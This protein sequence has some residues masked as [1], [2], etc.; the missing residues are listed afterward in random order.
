MKRPII[1]LLITA[2]CLSGF[3]T[4]RPRYAG[5]NTDIWWQ[6]DPVPNHLQMFN[7]QRRIGLHSR[8]PLTSI[9]SPKVPVIL[10][11]FSDLKFT[12]GLP[13]DESCVTSDQQVMVNDF[14]DKFCNGLRDGGYY[15]DHGSFGAI[16]EYF[17]DQSDGLFTPDFVVI[18]PVTLENGYATYGKNEK[19]TDSNISEFYKESV[20]KAQDLFNDWNLFDNDHNGTVD[21]MF[22]IYAGKGENFSNNPNAIWPKERPSG[23]T[24][25]S[26]TIGCYACCNEILSTG[27]PDGIGTFI[28]ELSHALGLPDLYDFGLLAYGMD[29][30]DIMDCGCYCNNSYWP[31]GY[32][33]Y[34]KDFMGWKPLVTLDDTEATHI[35]LKPQHAGGV[36]YKMVNPDNPDEYYVI[37]NRQNEEWDTYIGCMDYDIKAH[38]MV[39]THI[40]YA[41]SF[42]TG[43]WVNSTI[44][45]QRCTLVPA[46]GHLES[47][48][49][50]GCSYD[51]Y[52]KSS[53]GNP[54]PGTKNVTSCEA[55]KPTI[56]RYRDQ[57]TSELTTCKLPAV[58]IGAMDQALRNIVEHEDGTIEFDY[59][60]HGKMPIDADGL[61]ESKSSNETKVSSYDI[62]GRKIDKSQKGINIIRMSDGTTR[63]VLIK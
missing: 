18:G 63:K 47:Y 2:F 41:Q 62:N 49:N 17:R 34:E 38:G 36:G 61:N 44:E 57:K 6:E 33:A 31:C 50:N 52:I 51:Q 43:N 39:V 5:W 22:F 30:W 10:V 16:A 58:Y 15:T 29:Y 4:V 45:H 20:Q 24:I 14:F 3:A 59:C 1:T 9:G 46:D 13:K 54:F 28:H 40:D 8:A 55:R 56:L 7:G 60:P 26:V 23:G 53:L 35:V 19:G 21:M 32:S 48:I 12:S 11:Q 27:K 42:W 37:E 25:C